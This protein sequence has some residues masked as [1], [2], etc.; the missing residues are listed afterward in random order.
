MEEN[1]KNFTETAAHVNADAAAEGENS[2]DLKTILSMLILNWQWFALSVFIMLCGAVLYLKYSD[3][4]YQVSTKMLIKDEQNQ[5][6]GGANQMLANM[7]DLGFISNSAGIDNEVEILQSRILVREAVNDLKLYV[8]YKKDGKIKDRLI[9]K[10]QRVNVDLDPNSLQALENSKLPAKYNKVVVK[11]KYEEGTYSMEGL[12][13]NKEGEEVTFNRKFNGLPASFKT[14][15]GTLHF[16]F[17]RYM[18]QEE[19]DDRAV[20]ATILPPTTVAAMYQA[21]LSVEPT[22][23]TTSIALITLKDQSVARGEDFLNQLAVCYNRQANADKNEIALK[24]EE[25]INSRIEKIN[26]ELGLTEGELENYKKRY[27]VTQLQLDATQN[28]TQTSLLS[29]KL[30]DAQTQIELLDYLREFIDNPDN[31]YQ[32]IPSNVGLQDQS[33]TVLINQ[34]NQDVLARNKQLR[35]ASEIAPQVQT[36]TATLDELQRS[37]RV[38]LLQARRSADIQRKGIENEYAK[39]RNRVDNTPEQERI[40]NQIGRQQEVKSGLYL[41]LLQKRE[42]NSISLAATADKGKLIDEP[43]YQGKVSPKNM[44][45]MLVALVLGIG[46]PLLIIYLIQMM[47]YK[48]EGHEDVARL[49]TIPIVA[50]VAVAS[51]AAK[52]SAGIVVKENQNSQM[53]EI[54]RSLRTNVQFMLEEGQKVIL[55]TSST[56]GEGKTFNAANLAVS[57][58]LLG[59][60]VA[61]LGLDIRKPALG[62]LFNVADKSGGM[63]PLMAMA[64]VDK[65]AVKSQIRPSNVN[66]NL[67]L[68]LAGPIPPNPTELLARKNLI[69]IIEILKEDYDYI[70]LD[71][72]PVGL[73]TDTLQIA[74]LADVSCFVC[75]ADYT[76]K[77]AFTLVNSLAAEKKLKNICIVLNGVDMS[78]KKYGYYYGYG[79]YGKYGRYG[80]YG[81]YG[82]Y[83]N[84][85]SY[86]NYANSHYGKKDDNSIKK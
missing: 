42:E 6:R 79:R 85:G 58:A 48:I 1:K 49:T 22:S 55:F 16:T 35:S 39:Y 47:R 33:S 59:K 43:I 2:L 30:T 24:T 82:N 61:L 57:F 37:I 69:D 84:Y 75:R 14:P 27:N 32:I 15:A 34:Y 74:K 31:K 52:S 44:V 66:D 25:F 40:L 71:T 4:V 64:M 3:P 70:I 7:Q 17:N 10:S 60:K 72:A 63:T 38:A 12:C 13:Y 11:V 62:K 19:D 8:E 80:R 83:G 41:M 78:K 54:F 56:S 67:D 45:I 20:I 81:G 77:A 76:P 18:D 36:L 5:R 51:E 53:D 73:V 21:N 65:K 86:G 46:L 68:I 28:L 9:Y 23:K 50:D 26:A 29:S